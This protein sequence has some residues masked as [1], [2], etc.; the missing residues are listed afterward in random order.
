MFW[1]LALTFAFMVLILPHEPNLGVGNPTAFA[2][3]VL[4]RVETAIFEGLDR[5][6]ADLKANGSVSYSLQHPFIIKMD[7]RTMASL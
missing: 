4:V 5:V 7:E 6:R 1:K 3:V 2:P